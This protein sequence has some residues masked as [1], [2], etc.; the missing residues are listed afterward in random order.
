MTI[1]H[2]P[3]LRLEV[4]VLSCQLIEFYINSEN[5]YF[6]YLEKDPI[7][8]NLIGF[9]TLKNG[10]NIF[11]ML[12]A[13]DGSFPTY[14]LFYYDGKNIR[15]FLPTY[16][17]SLNFDFRTSI[18]DECEKEVNFDQIIDSYEKLGILEEGDIEEDY[19]EDDLY[20]EVPWSEIYLRKYSLTY[21]TLTFNWE[22]IEEDILTN[23]SLQED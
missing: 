13:G 18:G 23:L 22:A 3:S 7:G 16:G 20:F 17:N 1:H 5:I 8:K 15:S 19:D 6:N 9:K 14:V 12:M 11:G 2:P 10:I 4:G 21:D